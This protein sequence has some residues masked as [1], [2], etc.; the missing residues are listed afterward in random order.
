MLSLIGQCM[1]FFLT[2]GSACVVIKR[3]NVSFAGC[4]LRISSQVVGISPFVV[5]AIPFDFPVLLRILSLCLSLLLPGHSLVDFVLPQF[6]SL[7]HFIPGV[8]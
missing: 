5:L 8:Q 2:T 4:F 6:P 7:I 3:L 1:V